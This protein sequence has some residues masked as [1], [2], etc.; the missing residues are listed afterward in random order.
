M[1][2]AIIKGI[3]SHLPGQSSF[4]GTGGSTTSARYCYSVWLRHLIILYELKLNTQPNVII[5]FGPGNSIGIGLA[6]LFS[7]SKKYYALDVVDR[8][9]C[10]RNLQIFDEIIDL[11]SN[12]EDIPN[13]DEFHK[14]APRLKSYKFP[15]HIL[16]EE[17]LNNCFNKKRISMIRDNLLSSSQMRQQASLIRYVCQW[18]NAQSLDSE[19][20]DMIFSQAVLEHVENLEDTYEVMFRLL[21]KGGIMS[22]QIGFNSHGVSDFWNGQWSYSDFV[23]KLIKS[24]KPYL[25]NREPLSAHIDLLKK[26]GFKTVFVLSETDTKGINRGQLAKRFK[27]I[28]DEDLITSCA[29][30][31]SLK[32]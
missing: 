23:W 31:I 14:M 15:S 9:N 13:D 24:N 32:E 27:F 12:R 11:F 21:K 10:K 6:A 29:H 30:V 26:C 28:S 25:I 1:I 5:E 8:C 17:R 18:N 4:E 7:C 2:K 19:S 3:I 20:I 22:H 16:T